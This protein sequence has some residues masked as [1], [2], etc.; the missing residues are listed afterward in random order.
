MFSTEALSSLVADVCNMFVSNS[1]LVQFS[2]KTAWCQSCF[3]N[4]FGLKVRLW[5]EICQKVSAMNAGDAML[6][7]EGLVVGGV[8]LEYN[9]GPTTPGG[10]SCSYS[11]SISCP[12]FLTNLTVDLKM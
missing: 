10:V 9:P 7:V 1:S 6:G 5:V 11:V 2:S 3:I 4:G 8:W 12:A